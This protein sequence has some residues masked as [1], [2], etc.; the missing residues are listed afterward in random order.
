VL[1]ELEA[2]ARLLVGPA[3]LV[4]VATSI[5]WVARERRRAVVNPAKWLYVA[6]TGALFGVMLVHPLAGIM[7]Y[8]GAHSVEYFVIVH[9]SLGTR[10]SSA[11]TDGDAWLGRVVRA[12][13]G[14]LGFMGLYALAVSALV[15][16]VARLGSP[17]AYFVVF[18]T[19]GG[20]HV[21]YDAFIWKL[22]RPVVA[23][24]LAVPVSGVTS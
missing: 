24:S 17:L 16:G 22:R 8:V 12:R 18:F 20:M 10:Y 5:W 14:R 4:A 9:Q 15:V 2:V 13:P 7:G 1:L 19:L 23:R 6:A 11:A 3:A 21:F